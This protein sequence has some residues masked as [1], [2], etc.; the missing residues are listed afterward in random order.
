MEAK[1]KPPLMM[2]D[3]YEV[4]NNLDELRA[5]FDESKIVE[6]FKSGSLL[7]WLNAR[8]YD[9]VATSVREL[10]QEYEEQQAHLQSN[11]HLLAMA[12]NQADFEKLGQ[13]LTEAQSL[14][15]DHPNDVIA[16]KIA[17]LTQEYEAMKS[18]FS[19]P[20]KVNVGG[21]W[22]ALI[23]SL[24][25]TEPELDDTHL[26]E[27]LR[28]ILG[29][30][31]A[32]GKA[33]VF[34]REEEK[35]SKLR[36]QTDDE[37]ILAHA[38]QTAFTQEDM[39]E[40]LDAGEHT[41]YLCG[42]EFEIPVRVEGMSYVGIIGT[43]IAHIAAATIHD[44]KRRKITFSNITVDYLED[45]M[46]NFLSAIRGTM[47]RGLGDDVDAEFLIME[48]TSGGKS[49]IRNSIRQAAEEAEN[50]LIE[51][52]AKRVDRRLDRLEN[53][54]AQYER[55]C[56]ERGIVAQKPRPTLEEVRKALTEG[57]TQTVKALTGRLSK[58]LLSKASYEMLHFDMLRGSDYRLVNANKLDDVSDCL[59]Q[60]FI[61]QYQKQGMEG[62]VQ[63][64]L[65]ALQ[66]CADKLTE[67]NEK[68]TENGITA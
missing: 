6:Q 40:L 11:P 60:K 15:K 17:A 36:E 34:K 52:M 21:W 64:Y 54:Q 14:L 62:I 3:G 67:V 29:V 35:R 51:T 43:P 10:M 44:L 68:N 32:E 13:R 18:M 46:D 2:A 49:E 55:M 50:R 41:I 65:R 47:R 26:C 37:T 27:R 33:H 25:D 8:Y 57:H 20:P 22:S 19:A 53:L 30:K 48:E 16:E 58:K 66:R 38:A 39:A 61:A 42:H 59:Q 31:R 4:R 28:E 56:M 12:E 45:E 23:P 1:R 9:T 63:S 7:D 24:T 5:H